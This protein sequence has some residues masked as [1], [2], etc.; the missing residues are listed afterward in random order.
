MTPRRSGGLLALGNALAP[1]D[2][3]MRSAPG[4][5]EAAR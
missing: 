2:Q 5:A 4:H 1:N 3:E